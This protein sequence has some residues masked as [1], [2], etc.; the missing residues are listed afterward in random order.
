[1]ALY[2]IN[3]SFSDDFSYFRKTSQ[4]QIFTSVLSGIC[5]SQRSFCLSRWSTAL[6]LF[7]LRRVGT[8][9][10]LQAWTLEP[11]YLEA[12]SSSASQL[13]H[14]GPFFK[15]SVISTHLWNGDKNHSNVRGSL[16]KWN[17]IVSIRR[18]LEPYLVR[19][20]VSMVSLL[21]MLF[22]GG[23]ATRQMH[24]ARL[25]LG[26]EIFLKGC[27]SI[28]ICT[29]LRKYK[30][31]SSSVLSNVTAFSK[32]LSAKQQ[33]VAGIL[34]NSLTRGKDIEESQIKK[35]P[36]SSSRNDHN[37]INQPYFNKTWKNEEKK[38]RAKSLLLCQKPQEIS[39]WE[40]G[41]MTSFHNLRVFS[42]V[43]ILEGDRHGTWPVLMTQWMGHEAAWVT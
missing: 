21:Q 9:D 3:N 41:K 17:G 43:L 16:L 25:R 39:F 29:W 24:K 42:Q 2:V 30:N 5:I 20:K 4:F 33:R 15:D 23:A 14:L 38:K 19:T 7:S 22:R 12:D 36:E 13:N 37:L 6:I 1:M 18:D 10:W 40:P 31:E 27:W 32:S 11:I 26:A 28:L 35:S 34:I 8:V